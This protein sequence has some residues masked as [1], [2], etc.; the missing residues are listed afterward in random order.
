MT[1]E[2]LCA[3]LLSVSDNVYP[4]SA[5]KAAGV[6]YILYAV[7]AESAR[8]TDDRPDMQVMPGT[9]DLYCKSDKCPLIRD[10]PRVLADADVSFYLNSVQHEDETG[11]LHYEW[12][13]E[14]F[15]DGNN[16]N[17]VRQ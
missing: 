5:P 6:P 10:I 4:F 7:E 2:K 3:A 17:Q 13:F 15:D 8:W 1:L 12:V 16:Q 9:I 14:V 11:L